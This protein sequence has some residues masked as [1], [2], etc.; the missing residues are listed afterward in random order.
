MGSSHCSELMVCLIEAPE[1]VIPKGDKRPR[2]LDNELDAEVSDKIGDA[3]AADDAHAVFPGLFGK[4]E[5]NGKRHH[6]IEELFSSEKGHEPRK[7]IHGDRLDAAD[8]PVDSRVKPVEGGVDCL[9]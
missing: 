7:L 2:S 8:C 4:T 5:Y 9:I 3:Q 6:N 1:R